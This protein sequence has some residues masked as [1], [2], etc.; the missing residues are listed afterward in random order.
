MFK[1]GYDL[2]N[3][4]DFIERYTINNDVPSDIAVVNLTGF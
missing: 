3:F 4:L 2:E 1:N